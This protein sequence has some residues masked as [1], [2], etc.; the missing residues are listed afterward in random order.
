MTAVA[1]EKADMFEWV[2]QG[3]TVPLLLIYMPML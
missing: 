3:L 2:E 1:V